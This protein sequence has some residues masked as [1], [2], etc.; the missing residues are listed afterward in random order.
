[1]LDLEV[2]V[3]NDRRT[4]RGGTGLGIFYL[5][6]VDQVSHKESIFGYSNRFEGLGVYLNSILKSESRG[7]N[8]EIN[9]AVQGFWNDG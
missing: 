4:S 6:N 9:N 7:A 5:K 1:M 8:R 3:G 2:N